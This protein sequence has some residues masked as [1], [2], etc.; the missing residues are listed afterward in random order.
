[1]KNY[2]NYSR[3][4]LHLGNS[5]GCPSSRT[6]KRSQVC[7][8][9]GEQRCLRCH[10]T[11]ILNRGSGGLGQHQ[12]WVHLTR[13]D[14]ASKAMFQAR[15]LRALVQGNIKPGTHRRQKD[16]SPH[17]S[18]LRGSLPPQGA[19]FAWGG[20]AQNWPLLRG[21]FK[22][23][24]RLRPAPRPTAPA[25]RSAAGQGR[26]HFQ[27]RWRHPRVPQSGYS[28]QTDQTPG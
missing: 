15:A 27:W 16:C 1:M 14:H 10:R 4:R 26:R 6:G 8:I 21:W 9:Y 13:D 5:V 3:L 19:N 18:P 23:S 20:P 24:G 2:R 11:G 17:A 28:C 22:A 7:D 25:E 12:L